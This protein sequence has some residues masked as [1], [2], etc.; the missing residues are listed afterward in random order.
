MNIRRVLLAGV[1]WG[2]VPLTS[3]A[4]S[5]GDSGPRATVTP[6]SADQARQQAPLFAFLQEYFTALAQ[7]D[8]DKIVLYHPALTLSQC[9][10]LRAYFA[11]TVRDLHIDLRDV[12]VQPGAQAAIVTFV[13]TDRF[14]D[15]STERHIEKSIRFSTVLEY[16]GSGGGWRL[17]GLDM[18]AFALGTRPSQAG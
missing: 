18:I 17:E 1:L 13:R 7:G 8:V 14:V 11:H 6:A 2:M 12:Q 5:V 4:V 15:R 10:T 9:D 16:G 3:P